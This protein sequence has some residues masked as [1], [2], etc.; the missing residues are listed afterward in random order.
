MPGALHTAAWWAATVFPPRYEM[1]QG[2]S[3]LEL[4]KKNRKPTQLGA[5]PLP[6]VGEEAEGSHSWP[7]A[8]GASTLHS[9]PPRG[10]PLCHPPNPL[11][12]HL[13]LAAPST[14]SLLKVSAE[15]TNFR[16]QAKWGTQL[17]TAVLGLN[18]A[19]PGIP[20]AQET[21]HPHHSAQLWSRSFFGHLGATWW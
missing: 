6:Q 1:Q 3:R 5:V 10:L 15:L 7:Q 21:P 9:L 17:P 12:H 16:P 14:A 8:L 4:R 2:A 20:L 13:P 18:E 19:K 11:A